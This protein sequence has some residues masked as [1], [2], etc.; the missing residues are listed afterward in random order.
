MLWEQCSPID[1][2]T[3]DCVHSVI[4]PVSEADSRWRLSGFTSGVRGWKGARGYY[5]R[6]L[7]AASFGTPVTLPAAED[8]SGN[9][10]VRWAEQDL[11]AAKH[12]WHEARKIAV[13]RGDWR[14]SDYLRAARE[15]LEER[16]LDVSGV[17]VEAHARQVA[18]G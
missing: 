4:P 5:V 8:S 13:N 14:A 10:W 2:P 1:H 15:F 9:V 18:E 6:A 3:A 7:G 12:F 16:K 17:E 11:A